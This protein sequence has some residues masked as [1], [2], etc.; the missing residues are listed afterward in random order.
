MG[1]DVRSQDKA[2]GAASGAGGM[3]FDFFG[4]SESTAAPNPTRNFAAAA[5]IDGAGESESY[6][7]S[8]DV[9]QERSISIVRLDDIIASAKLFCRDK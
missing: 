8:Q 1:Y 9:E 7:I 6:S 3:T 2:D 4:P 5:V